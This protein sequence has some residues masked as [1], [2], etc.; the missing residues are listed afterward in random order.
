MRMRLASAAQPARTRLA[1]ADRLRGGPRNTRREH[2]QFLLQLRRA[3]MRAFSSLP[4]GG[5]HQDFAVSVAFV[6]MKF[7][8]R[9][10]TKVA[11]RAKISSPRS[12]VEVER[13]PLDT[14]S[15][16][17]AVPARRTS[18]GR[19]W[20]AAL[21]SLSTRFA[22]ADRAF[23]APNWLRPR[24][25]HGRRFHAPRSNVSR[26]RPPQSEQVP[27]RVTN[28]APQRGQQDW[29]AGSVGLGSAVSSSGFK[30]AL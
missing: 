28:C 10:G 6:T 26:G 27:V 25:R 23:A 11:G 30:P 16:A 2:G 5:P 22:A 18:L 21:V 15:G 4:F 8:D 1:S 29:F 19:G 20:S 24:R 14:P 12:L 17:R 9:H 13:A 7:V 3:A